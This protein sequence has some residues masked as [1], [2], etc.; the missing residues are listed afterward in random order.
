MDPFRII[1]ET[2]RDG[3]TGEVKQLSYTSSKVVGSGSFGVVMQVHLIESDSKA[4]I[5][6]VLQDKRFKVCIFIECK[7]RKEGLD[8]TLFFCENRTL[9]FTLKIRSA[10]ASSIYVRFIY[11]RLVVY[12]P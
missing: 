12:M 5:K 2:A 6:R 8:F 3:S 1:K 4:A 11:K 10:R 9:L 7:M